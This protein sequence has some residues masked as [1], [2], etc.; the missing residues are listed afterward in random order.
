MLKMAADFA[1]IIFCHIFAENLSIHNHDVM[2]GL[3]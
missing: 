2:E 1:I 3:T